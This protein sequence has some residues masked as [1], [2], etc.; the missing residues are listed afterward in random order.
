MRWLGRSLLVT[1]LLTAP[2]ASA[3]EAYSLEGKVVVE[4]EVP[5][6]RAPNASVSEGRIRPFAPVHFESGGDAVKPES[7]PALDAVAEVLTAN[8]AIELLRIEA[9]TDSV[10]SNNQALSQR[11]ADWVRRYLMQHGVEGERLTACGFGSSRPVASNET[12]AGRQANRRVE[13]VIYQRRE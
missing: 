4:V 10:A 6:P 8:P 13:F 3:Q 7:F 9:H 11:R 2:L 1:G 5:P 12:P